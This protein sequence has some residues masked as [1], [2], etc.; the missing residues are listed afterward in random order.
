MPVK[1]VS[2]MSDFS[3][4]EAYEENSSEQVRLGMDLNQR[5][6]PKIKFLILAV[7]LESFLKFLLI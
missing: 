6:N 4:A 1:P 7:V 2:E 5:I 3:A